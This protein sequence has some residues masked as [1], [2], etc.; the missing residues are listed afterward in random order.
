MSRGTDV[1]FLE[2]VGER[3]TGLGLDTVRRIVAG[4]HDG[5][6]QVDSGP[7]ETRFR[8][9]VPLDPIRRNGG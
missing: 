7:G 4:R 2:G 3:G 6:I 9:W 8:V 1:E 5:D